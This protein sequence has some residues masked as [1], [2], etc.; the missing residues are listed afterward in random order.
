MNSSI[1]TNFEDW[2]Y[3]ITKKCGL[4]LSQSFVQNRIQTL[5]NKEDLQTKALIGLYGEAH[6]QNTLIW[7]KMALQFNN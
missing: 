7:F 3:C 4:Q 1:P 5:E 6:Y 2:K